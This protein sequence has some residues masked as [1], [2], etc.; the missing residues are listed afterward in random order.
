MRA[1]GKPARI[2]AKMNALLEEGVIRAL[3]AASQ[4]GVEIDLIV[5]GACA[6]RPGV[7][8]LSDNIRVRSIL[9]RFLEHHRVWY[10]R[11]CRRRRTSGSR[12][13]TGWG[14]TSSGASRSRFRC[15]TW[16]S[17]S[18]SST[19]GCS[20]YLADNR[21]AWELEADGSMG[22]ARAARPRAARA[23]RSRRCSRDARARRKDEERRMDLVLWRHAE[24]EP[25]EPDLGRRLTAKGLKQAERMGALARP[26][27]CPTRR[28]SS[29]RRPIARSRRR[30][31]SS[32]SS[33][34][35]TRSAPGATATAV[36]AAAGLARFART[37]RRRRPPAHAR[38]RRVVPALRRGSVVVG[39]EGRGLVAVE[40]RPVRRIVGR[41]ARR[42]RARI[43]SDALGPVGQT[44]AR[45]IIRTS[46]GSPLPSIRR[47]SLASRCAVS[48]CA[49]SQRCR[50]ARRGSARRTR[51]RTSAAVD[52]APRVVEEHG[53]AQREE[54]RAKS[55]IGERCRPFSTARRGSR[56]RAAPASCCSPAE[57]PGMS[58]FCRM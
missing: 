31:G 23:R 4:A 36:L 37:G 55:R 58:A 5:R 28:A 51:T 24:A 22:E 53:E 26:L 7:R 48:G 20:A 2:V 39:Q 6:L 35:S 50:D 46:S 43:S 3:Y 10:F 11:Q 14:A 42:H 18:A 1:T 57:K 33:A 54:L 44:L 27:I 30:S 29:S 21:D 56:A 19:K 16:C 52:G 49:F 9:G 8:G 34:P 38:R 40:P 25:G 13:P 41:A 17:A 47:C 32:A 45:Q 12:R 15:A